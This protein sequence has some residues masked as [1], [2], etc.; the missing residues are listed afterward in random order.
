[1]SAQQ[2]VVSYSIKDFMKRHGLGRN[3]V[4]QEIANG[5]LKTIRVGRRRLIPQSCEV[6]WINKKLSQ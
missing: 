4:Y 5:N 1:M 3:S 6:D 2:T